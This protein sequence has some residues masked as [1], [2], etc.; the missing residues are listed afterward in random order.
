MGNLQDTVALQLGV[1]TATKRTQEL[2]E[3]KGTGLFNRNLMFKRLT[4]SRWA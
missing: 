4:H 2:V 1:N 3:T